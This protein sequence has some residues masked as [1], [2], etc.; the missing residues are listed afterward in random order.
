VSADG[1][2][3]SGG[4]VS[5]TEIKSWG[6]NAA[7]YLWGT[8]QGAWNEK[9]STSQI[10]ID[11]AIGMVPLVGDVT[12][13]RDLVAVCCRLAN[14][15]K[16]R[17]EAT[18]WVLLVVLLFALIPVIGGVIKGAGRILI[19]A[20]KDIAHVEPVFA[21]L[22]KIVNRL[23]HGNAVQW[24]RQLDLLKYQRQLVEKFGQFMDK[25][26]ETMDAISTRLSW[27]L[28]DEL[29]ASARYWSDQFKQLKA[30]GNKMIPRALKDLNGRLKQAQKALYQGEWHAVQPGTRTITREAE[31]R[32]QEFYSVRELPGSPGKFP[33]NVSL[34]RRPD[35]LEEIYK[36]KEGWPDLL[37][38]KHTRELPSRQGTFYSETIST[39]S[40]PI[41]AASK[42]GPR[43]LHRIIGIG[44]KD[45]IPGNFPAGA[46]WV[47][48]TK[49]PKSADEWREQWA[50]LNSFN[51]NGYVIFVDVPAGK[52]LNVWE[53]K[54]AEQWSKD[55][56]QYLQG[57]GVQDYIDFGLS[58]VSREEGAEMKAAFERG[59]HSYTTKEG[60]VFRI[61][62]T[63]WPDANAPI[64]FNIG[65]DIE[66]TA[67]ALEDAEYASKHGQAAGAATAARIQRA[68]QQRQDDKP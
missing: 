62:P 56:K 29:K 44:K 53:G 64:G 27:V 25:L 34:T 42:T 18:E 21:D 63:N 20:G 12:A 2:S 58:G 47:D 61:K 32:I 30:L 5:S 33:Q 60:F 39:F 45:D 50:V 40:G 66:G 23:C 1:N 67:Q 22:V 46:F 14:D 11:A 54:A 41:T 7:S 19:A 35:F 17:E 6:T 9:Q 15:P 31:A 55:G 57:G 68:T 48:G 26:I 59:A 24:L 51:H 65:N 36:P 37:G 8:V 28:S 16:K 43:T 13:G 4:G 38:Q 10:I 49:V 3:L 52:T